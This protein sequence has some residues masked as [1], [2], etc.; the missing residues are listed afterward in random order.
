MEQKTTLEKIRNAVN[1][2]HKVG[3][4]NMGSFILGA[5]SETKEQFDKTIKF[6]K[7]L[8]LD[9]VSFVPLKYMAGSD[10]W[11]KATAEGKIT[12]DMYVSK[13]GSERKLGLYPE[14]YIV[15]YCIKAREE[16]YRNPRIFLRLLIKSLKNDDFGFL[17]SYLSMFFSNI[18]EG[19]KFLGVKKAS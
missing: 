9:S 12:E 19:L 7:S 18:S 4:F 11:L 3:F 13:A 10:L 5:P 15:N 8:P 1:L 6:A 2:S 16:Y 14:K 17:Q